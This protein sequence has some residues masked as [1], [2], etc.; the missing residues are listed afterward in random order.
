MAVL[1][2]IKV[3]SPLLPSESISSSSP[4]RHHSFVA[5]LHRDFSLSSFTE[6]EKVKPPH[7]IE[8]GS[9]GFEEN[10]K[11]SLGKDMSFII[12]GYHQR[13]EFKALKEASD[14]KRT[15]E[16]H[17]G[18]S[19]LFCQRGYVLNLNLQSLKDNS[20]FTTRFLMK[21]RLSVLGIPGDFS[22]KARGYQATKP[23]LADLKIF[24]SATMLSP[25]SRPLL[26]PYSYR[27]RKTMP[28][29][30]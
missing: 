23:T 3:S 8:V 16:L 13:P 4:P 27:D 15:L 1:E 11:E 5:S 28:L 24:K 21:K 7:I 30:M 25:S 14:F 9:T 17:R 12:T 22:T 6:Q 19:V 26:D 10:L 29:S 20:S 18:E 2:K